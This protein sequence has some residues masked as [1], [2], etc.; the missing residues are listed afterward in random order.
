M[1]REISL[2]HKSTKPKFATIDTI[3][4]EEAPKF[5][6]SS[7]AKRF[8]SLSDFEDVK[9]IGKDSL[10]LTNEFRK[11][12]GKPPLIWN[13]KLCSIGA[14]H[15]KNMGDGKVPFSHDGFDGRVK[16]YPF[17]VHSAAENVAV[18]TKVTFNF[19]E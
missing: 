5:R 8:G 6:Q 9:R 3:P 14:V 18:Y 16:E 2:R 1:R 17:Q 12:R 11:K 7:P 13:D 15:S 19:Y 4:K 10:I